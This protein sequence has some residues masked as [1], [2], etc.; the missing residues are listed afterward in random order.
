[1]DPTLPQHLEFT[2]GQVS[3]LNYAAL[4]VARHEMGHALGFTD[5]F[6]YRDFGGPTQTDKWT[7]HISGTTFDPGTLNVQMNAP[8]DL[9]HVADDGATAG[10]L[11]TPALLYGDQPQISCT[12]L[13]ML[14]SAYHYAMIR[15][16]ANRDGSVGFEDLV[17][18]ARNYGQQNATWDQ[19]DFNNDGTVGF[20]D[21]VALARDYGKNLDTMTFDS[22]TAAASAAVATIPEPATVSLIAVAS[23]AILLRSAQ[24]RRLRRA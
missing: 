9:Q 10:D 13:K 20:D 16:D 1:M 11:M 5:A 7:S 2:T 14:E 19:G 23:I 15:G 22:S 6:Y 18:L 12:D 24:R 21:L 3:F 8:D 4:S 17:T